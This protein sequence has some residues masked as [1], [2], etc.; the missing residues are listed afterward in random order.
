MLSWSWSGVGRVRE[1]VGGEGLI[2]VWPV[3]SFVVEENWVGLR[4]DG[5]LDVMRIEWRE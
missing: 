2:L 3:K 1:V 5:R 4:V